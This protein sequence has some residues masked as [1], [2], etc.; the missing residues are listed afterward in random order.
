MHGTTPRLLTHKP[1]T[2]STTSKREYKMGVSPHGTTLNTNTDP[3][4]IDTMHATATTEMPTSESLVPSSP[5]LLPESRGPHVYAVLYT[6]HKSQKRKVW[7]DGKLVVPMPTHVSSSSSIHRGILYPAVPTPGTGDGVLDEIEWSHHHCHSSVVMGTRLET[8]QYL[9]EVQ[10]PWVP[11][12]TNPDNNNDHHDKN[13]GYPSRTTVP[14]KGMQKLLR[15]KFRKPPTKLPDVPP[16]TSFLHRRKR[17]LQPGELTKSQRYSVPAHVTE[18]TGT[19]SQPPSAPPGP[20]QPPPPSG[21]FPPSWSTMMDATVHPPATKSLPTHRVPSD[22]HTRPNGFD[23]ASFY[24]EDEEDDDDKNDNQN[25]VATAWNSLYLAET[26]QTSALTLSSLGTT[27]EPF[28]TNPDK[29][30]FNTTPV[31]AAATT[32]SQKIVRPATARDTG[33]NGS[34]IT[35]ATAS[36]V[37]TK[38]NYGTTES[39]VVPSKPTREIL[40]NAELLSL[41]GV[42]PVRTAA[43]L[44]P[45]RPQPSDIPPDDHHSFTLPPNADSEDSSEDE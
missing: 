29:E 33:D 20:Q 10:G 13:N 3:T 35:D 41:F 9:V 28:P 40:S 22:F 38:R 19:H 25:G 39:T 26:M 4:G 32:T 23:P 37:P 43:T 36:A 12:H 21:R 42:D 24:G 6:K 16:A 2:L 1:T 31:A 14:S 34:G 18:P 5:P 15:H 27:P 30:S 7:H 11:S 44:L 8:E 45:G 17:P